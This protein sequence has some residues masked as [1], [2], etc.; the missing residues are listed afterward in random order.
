[1][2]DTRRYMYKHREGEARFGVM[3]YD[4]HPEATI[5][6][7]LACRGIYELWLLAATKSNHLRNEK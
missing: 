2:K 3:L 1:M 4:G 7:R 5:S 6:N